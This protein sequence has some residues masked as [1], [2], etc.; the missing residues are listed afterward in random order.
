MEQFANDCMQA[1]DK[2]HF[3]IQTDPYILGK[4]MDREKINYW[5]KG[6]KGKGPLSQ[7]F[8]KCKFC[9]EKLSKPRYTEKGLNT[10]WKKTHW[11]EDGYM[12]TKNVC[13]IKNCK[14]VFPKS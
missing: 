8:F 9:P 10:H 13:P 6:K 5:A 7:A 3:K 11:K 14:Q 1:N 12:R 2:K 4:Y